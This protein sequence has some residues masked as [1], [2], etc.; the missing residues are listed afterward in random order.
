MKDFG[1]AKKTKKT[2]T[3]KEETLKITDVIVAV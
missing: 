2:T 3:K 1:S